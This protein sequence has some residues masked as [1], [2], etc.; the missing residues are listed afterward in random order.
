MLVGPATRRLET[1]AEE[2]ARARG[3]EASRDT[4][5]ALG[6]SEEGSQGTARLKRTAHRAEKHFEEQLAGVYARPA[7]ARRA[8][9]R[10]YEKEG[11]A[12]AMQAVAEDPAM[13]GTLKGT[14]VA[15]WESHKRR[16]AR[17]A[18]ETLHRPGGNYLAHAA[19]ARVLSG[20]R[21]IREG[22]EE[23]RTEARAAGQELREA[24]AGVYEHPREAQARF[25]E[26]AG[27][28]PKA[29]HYRTARRELAASPERFGA[30]RGESAGFMGDSGREAAREQAAGLPEKHERHL[31]LQR[32]LR[33]MERP[34]ARAQ[35]TLENFRREFGRV[36]TEIDGARGPEAIIDEAARVVGDAAPEE[37]AVIEDVLE[38]MAAGSEKHATGGRQPAERLGHRVE[39]AYGQATPEEKARLREVIA[40]IS[41]DGASEHLAEDSSPGE[42]ARAARGAYREAGSGDRDVLRAMLSEKHRGASAK[43]R[44]GASSRPQKTTLK[45][46]IAARREVARRL[47][48]ALGGKGQTKSVFATALAGRLQGIAIHQ[49]VD[50]TKKVAGI[51]REI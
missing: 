14:R 41:P 32:Q 38:G 28:A 17:S 4:L 51:G 33:R 30:L 50:T 49:A 3:L 8:F 7:A 15:G 26:A 40:H 31:R 9:D 2:Y 13:L 37:R 34:A 47:N 27:T 19:A 48:A 29:E 42:V 10:L 22:H 11:F 36:S 23:V 1:L 6:P 35:E 20:S 43:T 18:A 46:E 25:E 44:G 24:F 16:A 39:W 5:S 45:K 21:E 12:E